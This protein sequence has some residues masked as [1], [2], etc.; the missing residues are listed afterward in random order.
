MRKIVCYRRGC[1]NQATWKIPGNPTVYLCTVCM[2]RLVRGRTP[3]RL[4][5]D[6]TPPESESTPPVFIVGPTVVGPT[7]IKLGDVTSKLSDIAPKLGDVTSKLG[8]VTSEEV[9]DG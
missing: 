4:V 2:R 1:N 9:C 8:D 5:R 3:Q 6:H 7:E